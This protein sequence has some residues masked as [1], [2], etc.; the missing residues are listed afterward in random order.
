MKATF[1]MITYVLAKT[2][3]LGTPLI[4]RVTSIEC[5]LVGSSHNHYHRRTDA[6]HTVTGWRMHLTING[7]TTAQLEEEGWDKPLPLPLPLR[8]HHTHRV[9]GYTNSYRDYR[10]DD[11]WDGPFLQLVLNA[12]ATSSDSDLDKGKINHVSS[13]REVYK[14]FSERYAETRDWLYITNK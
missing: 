14:R 8:V 4:E 6:T 5:L 12:D 7:I 2:P 11:E 13:P 3:Y 1:Y 9:F 10:E